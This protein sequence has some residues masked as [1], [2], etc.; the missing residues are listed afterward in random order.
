METIIKTIVSN[1]GWTPGGVGIWLLVFMGLG[2]IGKEWREYRKL[3]I[4]DRNAR[5]EGYAQ[6]VEALMQENRALMSDM[7]DLRKEYD[8]H[9]KICQ[10]ETDQLRDM[11]VSLEGEVQGLKRRATVDAI[12]L[13]RL[14]GNQGT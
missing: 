9:R 1:P 7:R 11:I 2:W 6:Q 3:S 13:V 12:E 14:K 4:E 8:D 10:A 5:R